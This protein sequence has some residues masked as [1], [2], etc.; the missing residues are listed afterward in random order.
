MEESKRE[1]KRE[2]GDG[3]ERKREEGDGGERE[4]GRENETE[5]RES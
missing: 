1:G 4:R 2:E 5:L 3:G